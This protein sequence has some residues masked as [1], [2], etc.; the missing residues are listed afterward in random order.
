LGQNLNWLAVYSTSYVVTWNEEANNKYEVIVG[1]NPTNL[2]Q[3]D[4]PE[5]TS[6]GVLSPVM[7]ESLN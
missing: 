1:V 6:S 7:K 3:S 2:S 4:C 5:T